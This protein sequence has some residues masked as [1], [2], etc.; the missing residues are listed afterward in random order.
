MQPQEREA[1]W[2]LIRDDPFDR[3]RNEADLDALVTRLAA[4][5]ETPYADVLRRM[6]GMEELAE[7][8]A[9]ALFRR[10][11]EHWR[12]LSRSLGRAVHVRVAALDLLTMHPERVRTASSARPIVVT[13]SLLEK[14]LEEASSD[15]LTGLP[16]RAHFVG[17]VRHELRQR[18]RRSVAVA[19]VDLDR[20]KAVNDAYGHARG[21]EVLRALARSARVA[22]RHGDVLARMGGDEFAILLLD[23]SPEE[24]E[25][26]VNRLR[27]RFEHATAPLDVSFSAGV[28]I[29]HA[30]E[31]GE[32]A[33]DLLAR[34]DAGMYRDKRA[35]GRG[36]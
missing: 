17:L 20:F 19:W 12:R 27:D 16:Q 21:D 3:V 6:L 9:R 30:G 29:A 10:V 5:S 28:A 24:A 18:K 11:V 32:T 2:R 1:T 15:A 8:D 25:S 35:R 7:A 36:R 31:T 13:P 33:E 26:A 34:A 4:R 23:V 14:A 22:L